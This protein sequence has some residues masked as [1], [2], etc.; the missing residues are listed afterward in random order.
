MDARKYLIEKCVSV[1]ID[2]ENAGYEGIVVLLDA[3]ETLYG[4]EGL[5]ECRELHNKKLKEKRG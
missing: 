1:M 3:V 2:P 4:E 5:K